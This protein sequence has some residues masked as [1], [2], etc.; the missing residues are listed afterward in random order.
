MSNFFFINLFPMAQTT[1][2]LLLAL[3]VIA[4]SGYNP[5]PD[6][7]E[8]DD[9]TR[10]PLCHRG[11]VVDCASIIERICGTIDGKACKEF[12]NKCRFNIYNCGLYQTNKP[13]KLENYKFLSY[14]NVFLFFL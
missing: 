12:D 7:P 14:I 13:R 9:V 4:V 3:A 2:F 10:P 8:R 11:L 6:F 1:L 5:F